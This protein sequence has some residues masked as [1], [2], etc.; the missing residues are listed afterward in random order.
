MAEL[1]LTKWVT[2]DAAHEKT[3]YHVQHLTRLARAGDVPVQKIGRTW[4]FDLP[5]LLAYQTAAKPGA[6]KGTRRKPE[7]VTITR[8]EYEQLRLA[9]GLDVLGSEG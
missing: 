9:A 5:A 1:D 4:L 3:G 7:E 2:V 8:A 6:P